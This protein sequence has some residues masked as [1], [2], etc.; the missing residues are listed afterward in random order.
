MPTNRSR[1]TLFAVSA[2]CWLSGGCQRPQAAPAS[3]PALELAAGL[4][5]DHGG[6]VR[7]PR[8]ARRI[9]LIFTGGS[10]GEG[11]EHILDELGRRGVKASFFVTGDYVRAPEHRPWLKRMLAERHYLGPHSDAHLLYCPWEERGRTLVSREQFRR[12]LERN[13]DDLADLGTAR[14][15]MRFFVPPYE[16]YNEEIVRW[17]T[18]MGMV[19][20]SFTPGTRS[21]ADYLPDSHPRF[22]AS[23]EIYRG[24][25]AFE[26]GRPDGLNGFLL[27]LHLGVGPERSDKMHR[28]VGDLVDALSQRGYSFVRV[29]ELL[30]GAPQ[31]RHP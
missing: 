27:L 11:T 9:A 13:L 10:F 20:V 30:Q 23:E 15:G 21:N 8:D 16:W 26:S 2:L 18:E 3:R 4:T 29:D 17:A 22:I 5:Y 19:L 6:I 7:G 12:D 1:W 28:F 14:D 24:I 31:Y 25:L